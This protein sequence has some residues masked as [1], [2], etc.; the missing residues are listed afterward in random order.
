MPISGERNLLKFSK[1]NEKCLF[2]IYIIKKSLL[3]H[4]F[5]N[6]PFFLKIQQKPFLFL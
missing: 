3:N 4:R 1:L 2:F 6:K 5:L